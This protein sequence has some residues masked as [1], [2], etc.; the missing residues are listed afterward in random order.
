VTNPEQPRGASR[1]WRLLALVGAGLAALTGGLV[2]LTGLVASGDSGDPAPGIASTNLG[3]R[4]F[5]AE[6]SG[7]QAVSRRSGRPRPLCHPTARVRRPV[8]LRRRPGGRPSMRVAARTEWHS[9]RVFGVVRRRGDW[10]AVQAP[11]LRN[12]QV[13]WLPV[14]QARLGCTPWSLR[15]DLS[16]RRLDV[17][18]RGR[19]VRSMAVAIGRPGHETPRGRVSVT[20]KLRVTDPGSVYGCCVL[21]LSGHQTNL[22][23][24]WPGGDRLAVHATADLASIGSAASLG[25]L[26]GTPRDV[27][28]LI[29]TIPL[30]APVFVR[31]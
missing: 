12:G 1:N 15:A 11:E 5:I 31:S 2:A 23:P 7:A 14:R 9:P 25:C 13:G 29:E 28:W 20:D 22:P 19:T 6:R 17:R 21:A 26:R 3:T 24:G 16:R 30:G 18:H 8:A 4:H 27:R 10:L